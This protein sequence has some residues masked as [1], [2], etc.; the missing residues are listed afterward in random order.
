MYTP[1]D[2]VYILFETF[3]VYIKIREVFEVAELGG[4]VCIKLPKTPKYTPIM[5]METAMFAEKLQNLQHS[6]NSRKPKLYYYYC[7]YCC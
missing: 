7:Y 1:L 3:F 6:I 4:T 2:T 5:K